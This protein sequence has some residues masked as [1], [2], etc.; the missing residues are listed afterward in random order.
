MKHSDESDSK[1]NDVDHA[2]VELKS[3]LVSSF[4]GML[5]NTAANAEVFTK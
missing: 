5:I 1:L 4:P 3:N 2:R